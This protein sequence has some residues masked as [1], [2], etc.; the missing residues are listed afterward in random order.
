MQAFWNI[1]PSW[2]SLCEFSGC[3]NSA[4]DVEKTPYNKCALRRMK[5]TVTDAQ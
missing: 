3:I 4:N 2:M 1:N 5:N